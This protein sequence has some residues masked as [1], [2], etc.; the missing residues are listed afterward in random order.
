MNMNSAA[1]NAGAMNVNIEP[2]NLMECVQKMKDGTEM[3]ANGMNT[4]MK[5]LD[6]MAIALDVDQA[7]E[8]DQT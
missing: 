6:I 3:F 7:R 1:L 2:S 8:A 4:M 5:F